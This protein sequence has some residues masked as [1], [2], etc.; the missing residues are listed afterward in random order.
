MLSFVRMDSGWCVNVII[1]RLCDGC[2]QTRV[3]IA[4]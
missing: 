3:G 2:Q 1:K 4:S